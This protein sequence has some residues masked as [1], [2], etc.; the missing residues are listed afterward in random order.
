[1]KYADTF[2]VLV[3]RK[4]CTTAPSDKCIQI[5]IKKEKKKTKRKECSFDNAVIKILIFLKAVLYAGCLG[6]M[7]GS[8]V[9]I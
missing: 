6:I 3:L 7:Y 1:M 4:I 5:N 9:L 8:A 2:Q